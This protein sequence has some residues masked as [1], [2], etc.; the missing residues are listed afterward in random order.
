M[1]VKQAKVRP[2]ARC[3][4]AYS[5]HRDRMTILS[6]D[7]SL[8]N[9]LSVER[10]LDQGTTYWISIYVGFG[11]GTMGSINVAHLL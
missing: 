2:V 4:L 3:F 11:V 6:R 7:V 9:N 1:A 10:F 8:P 5:L